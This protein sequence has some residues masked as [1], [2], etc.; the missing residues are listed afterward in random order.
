MLLTFFLAPLHLLVSGICWFF[1]F[2]IP[3]SKLNWILLKTMYAHP[4]QIRCK[5]GDAFPSSDHSSIILLCTYHATGWRYY[6]YTYDGVNVFFYN[7]LAVV[8]FAIFNGTVVKRY[9]PDSAL[10]FAPFQFFTELISVIPLAYFIGMA[11]SSISAQ[12]SYGVAAVLNAT[13][14][15]IIEVIL[16]LIA[17]AD[18]KLELVEGALIGS[19]L[20]SV[21]LLP[22][23]SMIAGGIKVKEQ[24][25]N[26][27]SAGVTTTLLIM[28]LIGA[29]APSVFHAKY[30]SVH[31]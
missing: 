17:I 18:G 23:I 9:F 27:K 29:F 10:A 2:S 1:V 5:R 20:F 22:G 19:I 31:S 24:K 3:M 25:F 13:F 26:A 15:S 11:V 12:T 16:Y 6:K 7:L 14:G 30:G 28:S 21:L 4:Q 8:F